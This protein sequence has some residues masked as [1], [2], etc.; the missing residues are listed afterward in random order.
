MFGVS[1]ALIA[2]GMNLMSARIHRGASWL[3]QY[4][5]PPQ[6]GPQNTGQFSLASV[7]Y[8][9]TNSAIVLAAALLT[10]WAPMAAASGFEASDC[11]GFESFLSSQLELHQ[12]HSRRRR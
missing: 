2:A 1:C 11:T 12:S 6:N 8:V 5:M 4:V 10:C 3:M 9:G 7:T